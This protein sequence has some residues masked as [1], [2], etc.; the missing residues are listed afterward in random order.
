MSCA[1]PAIRRPL[2]RLLRLTL[3]GL[4]SFGVLAGGARLWASPQE[5]PCAEP[6]TA[7]GEGLR[8]DLKSICAL[9]TDCGNNLCERGEDCSTC[10]FDCG[11]C[12][13][14]GDSTC[15]AG[16]TCSNCSWDCG[17]CPG[18][19]VCTNQVPAMTSPTAPSG[20]V[21]RSSVF[22]S[23]FE[24]F[25]AFDSSSTSMWVS[26]VGQTPAWVAYA[27]TSPRYV[28]KYSITY[29]NGTILTRAPRDWEL[30]GWNGSSWTTIHSRVGQ[31]SW[32][33]LE[34]RSF[35]VTLP[36]SYTSY[37]LHVTEDNDDRPSPAGIVALSLGRLTLES[38]SDP[39]FCGS[40]MLCSSEAQCDRMCDTGNPANSGGQCIGGCC[41]CY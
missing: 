27:A 29:S 32:L 24:G 36:A 35:V 1:S 18:W 25:Q 34:T 6:L 30:Q 15:D 11:D 31:R 10:S 8:D 9:A 28:N 4:T 26:N 39:T 37:R 33:G 21:T 2:P 16:E 14:C 41:Y 40:S 12:A 3:F 17:Q 38:C 22:N 13:V 5:I 19:K 20:Q 23:G 7:P